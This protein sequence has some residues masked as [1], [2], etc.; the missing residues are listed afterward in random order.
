[1]IGAFVS[2]HLQAYDDKTAARA[3]LEPISQHLLEG[4]L[5]SISE[6]LDGDAPFTPRGC[7]WQAWSVA[8]I[9]RA[10]KLTAPSEKPKTKNGKKVK[11]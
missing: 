6:I 10:W 9:L 4:G 5:G 3:F 11:A 8:E 2:A 7:P 1:L